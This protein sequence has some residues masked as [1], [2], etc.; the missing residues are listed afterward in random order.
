MKLSK[1]LSAL[2]ITAIAGATSLHAAPA[3]GEAAPAFTLTD[4]NG[5]EHSL[6]DFAGKVVVLEWV[7][8]GCPFVKK[9]YDAGKMQELQETYTGKDV[10]WLKV[11]SS[12][13]G[14][15]GYHTAEEWNALND[16]KKVKATATLLDTDG[17]VGKAYDARVTPHMFVINAEGILVYDGAIDSISSAD[18]ADIDKADNY[19]VAALDAV[20]EGKAVAEAKTKPYGCSVKY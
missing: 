2:A 13:E 18:A 3:I 11:A 20:I 9:F 19:V 17:T 1:Y 10:V 4:T 8:H 16:E 6:S 5:T 15:Q 7:N 14:K 12:N